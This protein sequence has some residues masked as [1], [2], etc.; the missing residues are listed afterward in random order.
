MSFDNDNDNVQRWF[1][2]MVNDPDQ[3]AKLR[4][5]DAIEDYKNIIQQCHE[6]LELT[7]LREQDMCYKLTSILRETKEDL[8]RTELEYRHKPIK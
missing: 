2:R 7:P 4:Y 8:E 3:F 1:Y 6:L 5:A